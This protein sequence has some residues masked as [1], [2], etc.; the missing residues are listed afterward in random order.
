MGP[1]S[2]LPGEI[3]ESRQSQPQ[4]KGPFSAPPFCACLHPFAET[5]PG[6]ELQ[7]VIEAK[8]QREGRRQI[9]EEGRNTGHAD[10]CSLLV[11][12]DCQK[13][14]KEVGSLQSDQRRKGPGF[15]GGGWLWEVE[16]EIK[17]K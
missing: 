7:R 15:A 14:S 9:K 2:H 10:V 17:W 13:T 12:E 8:G 11:G 3:P 6:R 5:G 4:G 16:A 1:Q